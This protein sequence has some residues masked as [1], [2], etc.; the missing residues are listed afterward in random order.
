MISQ[1]VENFLKNW[2]RA[3]FEF[4]E[5]PTDIADDIVNT[6]IQKFHENGTEQ[7]TD[8][9]LFDLFKK[10]RGV[11]RDNRRKYGSNRKN[12]HAREDSPWDLFEFKKDALYLDFG[13]NN[14]RNIN[15]F[16]QLYPEMKFIGMDIHAYEDTLGFD[17]PDRCEYFQVDTELKNIPNIRKTF[18]APDYIIVKLMMHHLES[19]EI[20][21]RLL[22]FLHEVSG[23]QTQIII[24]E[25]TYYKNFTEQEIKKLTEKNNQHGIFTDEN[26]SKEFYS[27]T[28]EEREQVLLINDMLLNYANP[29]MQWTLLYKSWEEWQ[30][31]F[32]GFGFN[33]KETFHLGARVNGKVQQGFHTI[34]V[35]QK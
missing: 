13:A 11:K 25:E 1:Q 2:Y 7:T 28:I 26:L 10:S 23:E 14:L 21:E 29:H 31:L 27:L 34:G 35:F 6:G 8:Q 24:W 12:Y 19:Q 3:N 20:L 33:L 9:Q 17:F 15:I 22:K 18:E 32:K 4:A 16:A 5:I 30:D